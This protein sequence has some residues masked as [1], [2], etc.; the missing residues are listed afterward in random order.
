M[1][2]SEGESKILFSLDIGGTWS[3]VDFSRRVWPNGVGI[4]FRV[5]GGFN[6][7]KGSSLTAEDG[8][9][10]CRRDKQNPRD[11]LLTNSFMKIFLKILCNI[12]IP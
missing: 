4:I 11:S 3:I 6:Y 1:T 5:C 9:V 12:V 7:S 2:F 8:R 10:K